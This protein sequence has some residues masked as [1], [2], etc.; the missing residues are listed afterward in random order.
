MLGRGADL[1][2]WHRADNA[3]VVDETALISKLR[4]VERRWVNDGELPSVERCRAQLAQW[5]QRERDTEVRYSVPGAMQK[6]VFMAIS[7]RYGLVPYR[8]SRRSTATVCLR[9]PREFVADVLWPQFDA[10]MSVVEQEV[11]KALMR[12]MESWAEV[13]FDTLKGWTNEP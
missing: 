12:V 1:A 3:V 7:H 13:S 2:A 8:P 4:A 6:R 10:M 9:A 11:D 5:R